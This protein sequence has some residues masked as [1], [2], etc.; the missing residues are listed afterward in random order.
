MQNENYQGYRNYA[1]WSVAF[2]IMADDELYPL[3]KSFR[4]KGYQAFTGHLE[5][6]SMPLETV[7]GI[8]WNDPSLD[9]H[10]L[11]KLLR[12]I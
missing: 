8:S 3:A 1:T 11:N 5:D 7:D 4:D 6:T 9:T 2:W 12:S 10:A